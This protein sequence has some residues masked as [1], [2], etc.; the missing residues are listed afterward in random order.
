VKALAGLY[1]STA[2]LMPFGKWYDDYR[3]ISLKVD[4][5]LAYRAFVRNHRGKRQK[6]RRK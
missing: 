6:K 1:T 5:E 2:S 4:S 3:S